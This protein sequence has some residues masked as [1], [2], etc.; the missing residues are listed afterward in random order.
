MAGR[1]SITNLSFCNKSSIAGLTTA[2]HL[3]YKAIC[4]NKLTA[5]PQR[6]LEM[7]EDSNSLE[8]QALSA[9]EDTQKETSS[10][11]MAMVIEVQAS[12]Q[13]LIDLQKLSLTSKRFEE[14]ELDDYCQAQ[15]V[16]HRKR[17][18]ELLQSNITVAKSLLSD[19]KGPL[20]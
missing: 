16:K 10:T 17:C 1:D 15:M 2:G 14:K 18:L 19:D 20:M 8:L 7:N 5:H 9:L 6:P 3:G 12:L 4:L 11:L 13:V